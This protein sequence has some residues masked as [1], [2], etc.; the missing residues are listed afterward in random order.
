MLTTLYKINTEVYDELGSGFDEIPLQSALADD[1]SAYEESINFWCRYA[2]VY[3]PAVME[4]PFESAW[5][6]IL[7]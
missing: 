7:T 4:I 5:H 3:D 1:P 2:L 6:I